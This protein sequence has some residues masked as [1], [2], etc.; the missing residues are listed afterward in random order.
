LIDLDKITEAIEKIGVV[1][2]KID[3]LFLL[4]QM[5]AKLA[6]AHKEIIKKQY[7]DT[8]P[9]DLDVDFESILK[10]DVS[11]DGGETTPS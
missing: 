2:G 8:L 5:L 9:P 1:A 7:P 4:G 3:K 11:P 10:D 6:N